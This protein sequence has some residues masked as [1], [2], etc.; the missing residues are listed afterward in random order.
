M[1]KH[2]RDDFP[3]LL[4]RRNDCRLCYL[5][6]AAT[7]QKPESV[8]DAEREY[9]LK[10][11]ANPHRGAYSLSIEATEMYESARA[12]VARFIGASSPDEIVFTRN[13]TEALNLLAYSYGMQN[14]EPGD[15]I[16]IPIS[17]HHSNLV[18]W[19]QVAKAKGAELRY[20]YLNENCEL[21]EEEIRSKIVPGV[22]IVSVARVS[23]ALGVIHP[24]DAIVARA[25]EVGAIAIVDE[26][27]SIPHM[28]VDVKKTD[29][30]FAAFSGHKMLA[31][32]GIGVLYGKKELLAHMPPFLYGGDMI[33]YVQEQTSTFAPAPAKF[34]AGTQNVGGAVSLSA[35]IDY[36]DS[37]GMKNIEEE[38]W[39]LTRYALE[40]M[41]QIPHLS[42]YGPQLHSSQG[43]QGAIPAP[44]R[45]GIIS[46]N[47][48][49]CHPHDVASILDAQGVCV[50]S[51]HHCAQPLMK[52]MGLNATCRASFYLYNNE[53]DVDQLVQALAN[54]RE[55]MRVK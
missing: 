35:A 40:Q 32:M 50:R 27:Q 37:V 41:A 34:E 4:Q 22:K 20:M 17:E 2:Y 26:A 6:S 10:H 49:G 31:G 25:H 29:M 38:E 19:Q 33:E 8:L 42:I 55:I 7:S 36:L 47:V 46:F 15:V 16:V 39:A 45:S 30:E 53:D 11:N 5:D 51:G 43:R 9:Y 3:A 14:I 24:V 12:K 48:D 18:P 44:N 1:P 13:T 54:V 23:N 28:P 52:F 21:T